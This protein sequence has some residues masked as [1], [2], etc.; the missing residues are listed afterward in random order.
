MDIQSYKTTYVNNKTVSKNWI[1]VDAEAAILGR[2]SSN[3]AMILRGKNKTSFTPFVDCGDN[4]I[5]INAEKV[6]LTGKKMTDRVHVRYTGYPGGQ[7]FASPSEILDKNPKRLI[8]LAVR[9]M[10]PK[11]RM[12]RKQFTNLYVYEGTNHPHAAQ[13]PKTI[14]LS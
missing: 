7:R 3:I 9:R 4:V 11:T 13:N 8:E 2:M 12:G 10:L 14:S 1:V 6:R 5:V